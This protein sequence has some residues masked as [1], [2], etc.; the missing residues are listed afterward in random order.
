MADGKVFGV[1]SSGKEWELPDYTN[2]A[3]WFPVAFGG[4]GTH[5]AAASAPSTFVPADFAAD[6]VAVLMFMGQSN[7]VGYNTQPARFISPASPNVWGIKNAGWNFLAGNDNGTTPFTG[8]I[9]SI[10]S[11]QW[12]PW[13]IAATG[14]DMNLGFNNN[15]GAGGNAANFAA[16]QW[17]GLVN[18]GW[19]LPDLYIIHIGWPSQGVDALDTTTAVAAWLTHG[20]NLW[21]PGLTSAQQ[22]SYALAPF[23]RMVAWR[24]MQSI[25]AAGR[26]PRVLG[27]QWNQWE[28]EAGNAN[29]AVLTNAPTN[30]RNLVSSFNSTLGTAFPIEFVKPLSQAYSA[31]TLSTMQSAFASLAATDATHL[32]VIDV[33]QVSSSIFSGGVLGG[34]DGA[35]HYNLDTHQWFANQAMLPCLRFGSCGTRITTLPAATPN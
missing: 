26:K 7:A 23:A 6:E 31:S 22:P 20:E 28:A 12:T 5:L 30:Y 9:S 32:S 10:T 11:V 4:V 33:S 14:T 3:T 35:I 8:A 1:D 25:L 27:L 18:A 17:Q 19:K 16:Y 21:Q 24:G 34:G 2:T 29:T 15:A 13:S